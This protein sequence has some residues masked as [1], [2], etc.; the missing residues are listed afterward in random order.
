MIGPQEMLKDLVL[1]GGS[2][3]TKYGAQEMQMHQK[4]D[5]L[6]KNILPYKSMR[7]LEKSK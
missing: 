6:G 4:K 7:K 1:K 3:N 5:M 2:L